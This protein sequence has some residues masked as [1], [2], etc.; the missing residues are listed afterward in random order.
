M[1]SL[2]VFKHPPQDPIDPIGDCRTLKDITEIW[3]WE[4]PAQ[5]SSRSVADFAEAEEHG[6][7]IQVE[8]RV[9]G[10]LDVDEWDAVGNASVGVT[11]SA[12]AKDPSVDGRHVV[13]TV[14]GA[15]AHAALSTAPEGHGVVSGEVEVFQGAAAI[16]PAVLAVFSRLRFSDEVRRGLRL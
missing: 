14:A 16:D 6:G 9:V 12:A 1:V 5:R 3:Y 13:S 11:S 7:A 4:C 10:D 8:N 2:Y 15:S